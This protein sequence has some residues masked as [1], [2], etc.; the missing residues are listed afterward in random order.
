MNVSW[1]DWVIAAVIFITIAWSGAFSGKRIKGV[2]DFLLAGRNVRKYLGL[3]TG[4]A[5]GIGLITIAYV[6]QQGFLYGLSFI[7]MASLGMIIV[8]VVFGFFGVVIVRFRRGGFMTIPQY[9]EWRYSKNLRL[10]VGIVTAFAG[11]LNFAVFP[12]VGSHFLTY[13]LGINPTMNMLG[14]AVPTI[15]FIMAALIALALIFTNLGGML[16]VLL[17]DYLQSILV[18]VGIFI[19]LV[20]SFKHATI[21]GLVDGL[22]TYRGEAAFNPFLAGSYGPT[23]FLWVL[24]NTIFGYIAFAPTMQKIASTDNPRTAQLM[25]MIAEILNKGRLFMV[26]L[27]GVAAMVML[28]PSVPADLN[29][30]AEEWSRR[31]TPIFLGSII[32]I[33]LMGIVMATLFAT[34][35]TSSSAYMLSWASIIVNDIICVVRPKPMTQHSHLWALKGVIFGIAAFLFLFGIVYKPTET[36]LEY[37]FITGTM[38]TGVGIAVVLGIYWKKGTT[39]GACTA[40]I[41]AGALPI[42]DLLLKRV[43]P[44]YHLLPQY[45]GLITIG[46]AIAGY[47]VVS[48]VPRILG[49]QIQDADLTVF[50]EKDRLAKEKSNV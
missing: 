26:M 34:F 40:V 45:T 38:F 27:L 24:L 7:W 25:T 9:F 21:T 48:M 29:I 1:I 19:M 8:V 14:F 6:A 36:I 50:E 18:A 43:C 23:F 28:G 37:I 17:T 42:L 4:M 2:A 22:R 20:W 13:F 10:V 41:T 11:L 3:S 12:I 16:S 31:A 39:A 32:P 15:P 47:I 44:S 5:D 46:S 49:K 30:S 33:G 35:I